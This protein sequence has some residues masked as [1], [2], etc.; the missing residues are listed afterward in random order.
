MRDMV[1]SGDMLSTVVILEQRIRNQPDDPTS[2][3]LLGIHHP[4]GHSLEKTLEN[5]EIAV[6]VGPDDL[7][8]HQ[9]LELVLGKMVRSEEGLLHLDEALC[10]RCIERC[11]K[12]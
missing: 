2:W 8:L 6:K 4:D 10:T 12:T 7:D 3:K 5:L 11:D 1:M 9:W